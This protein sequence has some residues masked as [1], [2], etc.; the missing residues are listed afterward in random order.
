[1]SKIELLDYTVRASMTNRND[2]RKYSEFADLVAGLELAKIENIELGY[3]MDDKSGI[4]TPNIDSI[5]DYDYLVTNDNAIYSVMV[6]PTGFDCSSL[7]ERCG[8][9]SNI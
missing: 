9:I 6:H 4:C 8:K 1:M 5:Q 2:M 3:L 7:P